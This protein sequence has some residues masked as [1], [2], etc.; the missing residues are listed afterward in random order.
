M[1]PASILP[2]SS[3]P[4]QNPPTTQPRAVRQQA[5]SVGR[6]FL[7][8]IFV[9]FLV[10]LFPQL[11]GYG[12]LQS[13]PTSH[14]TESPKPNFSQDTTS[15]QHRAGRALQATQPTSLPFGGQPLGPTPSVFNRSGAVVHTNSTRTDVVYVDLATGQLNRILV[16]PDGTPSTPLTFTAS[17]SGFSTSNSVQTPH[18]LI[19]HPDG[20]QWVVYMNG[21]TSVNAN[22]Y[23]AHILTDNTVQTYPVDTDTNFPSKGFPKAALLSNGNLIVFWQAYLTD[24]SG[25]GMLAQELDTTTGQILGSP[26]SVNLTTTNNQAIFEIVELGTDT[27]G[28]IFLDTSTSP[29]R[30]LFRKFDLS[31]TFSGPEVVLATDSP[32]L[33][34]AY[35]TSVVDAANRVLSVFQASGVDDGSSVH[36][37]PHNS[38]GTPDVHGGF[39][40]NRYGKGNQYFPVIG[41]AKDRPVIA[42]SSPEFGI[43]QSVI[44][45]N[46]EGVDLQ[47]LDPRLKPTG[48]Q[49]HLSSP[50]GY[51]QSPSI[52]CNAGVCELAFSTTEL[53]G[54]NQGSSTNR[55]QLPLVPT[56]PLPP[57][58]A[59]TG[60]PFSQTLTGDCF[61]DPLHQITLSVTNTPAWMSVTQNPYG[62]IGSFNNG[63]PSSKFVL[64]S[65]IGFLAQPD[66]VVIVDLKNL[67]APIELGTLT[68]FSG[69][70]SVCIIG[71][72]LLI[73]DDTSLYVYPLDRNFEAPTLGTTLVGST[74]FGTGL[75]DDRAAYTQY[76]YFTSG[77]KV[78]VVDT[79]ASPPTVQ[80]TTT[81]GGTVAQV[82]VYGN[83]LIAAVGTK[84]LEVRDRSNPLGSL[85]AVCTNT[86]PNNHN[87]IAI[88]NTTGIG[89]V[90]D[91]NGGVIA[92]DLTGIQTGIP[93]PVLF[94]VPVAGNCLCLELFDGRLYVGTTTGYAI[95]AISPTGAT[96]LESGTV[97]GGIQQLENRGGVLVGSNTDGLVILAKSVTLSGTPGTADI[98]TVTPRFQATTQDQAVYIPLSIQVSS[99]ASVPAELTV[100]SD[101][102]GT[103]KTPAIAV[104]A[105][106]SQ[107]VTWQGP[108]GSGQGVFFQV[109]S[110]DRIKLGLQKR[111]AIDGLADDKPP[112]LAIAPTTQDALIAWP[113]T[114]ATPANRG[115]SFFVVNQNQAL[116]GQSTLINVDVASATSPAVAAQNNQ[117]NVFWITTSGEV[118][119]QAV[120]FQNTPTGSITS[121]LSTDVDITGGLSATGF[122]DGKGWALASVDTTADPQTTVVRLT[123]QTPSASFSVQLPSISGTQ[124]RN[125]VVAQ[126]SNGDL[127]VACEHKTGTNPSEVYVTVYSATGTLKYGPILASQ[128]GV[129]STNPVI[130][131][132]L[133]GRFV[134]SWYGNSG[135]ADEIDV[136]FFSNNPTAWA[137]RQ[138]AIANV[139][140]TGTH[141]SPALGQISN[142]KVVVA[143]QTDKDGTPDIVAATLSLKI[144]PKTPVPT[145]SV[146]I[147]TT[148]NITLDPDSLFQ[149]FNSPVTIQSVSGPSFVSYNSNTKVVTIT[150]PLRGQGTYTVTITGLDGDGYTA[151]STFTVIVPNQTPVLPP[152]TAG[153][154]QLGI[155]H[156][157]PTISPSDADGDPLTTT[158]TA[159]P[160]G[161]PRPFPTTPSLGNFTV[162]SNALNVTVSDPSGATTWRQWDL[163]VGSSLS[164][165]T[166]PSVTTNENQDQT[167]SVLFATPAT[168]VTVTVVD[169]PLGTLA[170]PGQAAATSF[171]DAPL[172]LNTLEFKPYDNAF[173]TSTIRLR[174]ND[175][176]NPEQEILIPVTVQQQTRPLQQ[177]KPVAP[178]TTYAGLSS[179]LTWDAD[180]VVDPRNTTITY[181]VVQADGSPLPSWLVFDGV[182]TLTATT[183]TFQRGTTVS[184][185]LIANDAHNYE[186]AKEIPFTWTIPANRAPVLTTPYLPRTLAISNS[187]T[188]ADLAPDT[189]LTDTDGDPLSFSYFDETTG[190]PITFPW[191]PSQTALGLHRI[192]ITATDVLGAQTDAFQE[193]TVVKSNT[194]TLPTALSTP[195]DQPIILTPIIQSPSTSASL[196]ATSTI[197]GIFTQLDGTPITFPLTGTPSQLSQS[198][199]FVPDLNWFGTGEVVF[200]ISD[201]NLNPVEV[202]RV[203]TTVQQ[204]SKPIQTTTPPSQSTY[205][206]L[207]VGF[208]LPSTTFTDQRGDAIVYSA[209]LIDGSP[210]PAHLI[211]FDP[212][213]RTFT[214]VTTLGAIGTAPLTIKV[215]GTLKNNPTLETPADITFVWSIKAPLSTTLSE[216]PTPLNYV[217]GNPQKLPSVPLTSQGS[218]TVRLVYTL[219]GYN[220]TATLAC[221]AVAPG[222]TITQDQAAGQL[223]LTASEAD[224]ANLMYVADNVYFEPNLGINGPG[225][226]KIQASNSQ[227]SLQR[228]LPVQGTALP[229]APRLSASL[230][231]LN[232]KSGDT[233]SINLTDYITCDDGPVRFTTVQIL[234]LDSGLSFSNGILSGTVQAG[235]PDQPSIIQIVVDT[236]NAAPTPGEIR[237][238]R[239]L[240]T[241]TVQPSTT[242]DI[243]RSTQR[244][245]SG[246]PCLLPLPNVTL[247]GP[248]PAQLLLDFDAS[249]FSVTPSENSSGVVV[250][251]STHQY[252]FSGLA[253]ALN[254]FWAGSRWS[255][256]TLATTAS[257]LNITVGSTNQPPKT[258][259]IPISPYFPQVTVPFNQTRTNRDEFTLFLGSR[260]RGLQGTL[261]VE[262]FKDGRP[263]SDFSYNADT[264]ELTMNP[265]T[266]SPSGEYTFRIRG[267]YCGEI[268]HAATITFPDLDEETAAILDSITDASSSI[269][270]GTAAAALGVALMFLQC[271]FPDTIKKLR[272]R[273]IGAICRRI[274]ERGLFQKANTELSTA[275]LKIDKACKT[276]LKNPDLETE[277]PGSIT[278]ITLQTQFARDLKQIEDTVNQTLSP[279]IKLLDKNPTQEIARRLEHLLTQF[280]N[281]LEALGLFTSQKLAAPNPQT[282]LT[283]GFSTQ[284]AHLQKILTQLESVCN[285]GK[286]AAHLLTKKSVAK[287]GQLS[288]P[289]S[290]ETSRRSSDTSSTVPSVGS[291][292]DSL[293]SAKPPGA[294]TPSTADSHEPLTMFRSLPLHD[295]ETQTDPLSPLHAAFEAIRRSRKAIPTHVPMPTII[296]I[297]TDTTLNQQQAFKLGT[298]QLLATRLGR[299]PLRI[300]PPLTSESSDTPPAL[301]PEFTPDLPN[302]AKTE[303][304][305]QSQ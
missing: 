115:I 198:I 252:T 261:T 287:L 222:V 14:P 240:T 95:Y 278:L 31:G 149:E 185:K 96:L 233:V 13:T 141:A 155:Q 93:V 34:L 108:L 127:A 264:N 69:T 114:S 8:L 194:Y 295:Q 297:P 215:T 98:G 168:Q 23:A 43:T 229:S 263:V 17:S 241:W 273:M 4:P 199:R 68:G 167:L 32:S 61:Y 55:V 176:I 74:P 190:L 298:A 91:R 165:T 138:T 106:G 81:L 209:T 288:D 133:T 123:K 128:A 182:R 271:V 99:V 212:D 80:A 253:Q 195:E 10:R 181:T 179:T 267:D 244:F 243:D 237:T 282:A 97:N 188:E 152:I 163:T 62:Q 177:Q 46:A 300:L 40:I 131:V 208:Q 56:Q 160:S 178:Q 239:F 72:K 15:I 77:N 6:V 102:T 48:P 92:Y 231:V 285:H 150:P 249:R 126:L 130:R 9:L 286:S 12:Q 245:S 302:V 70:P 296:P 64:Y 289:P 26:Q 236:D 225:Q 66:R 47:F 260:I 124:Q 184:L 153:T 166:P 246:Q 272:D 230:P 132:D 36:L 196:S 57:V 42:W 143:Y 29:S 16:S 59:P 290:P 94:R 174:I 248:F 89:W 105:D 139:T 5:A 180:T 25:Y 256:T 82:G 120:S 200:T 161:A 119:T 146:F 116:F 234:P 148:L 38:T 117:F 71:H 121:L 266:L 280:Q 251:H 53:G 283:E 255:P 304:G 18:K 164:C 162:G 73:G 11:V 1:A 301:A 103:Q 142:E 39:R 202:T 52:D 207:N 303:S 171:T 41:Q 206:G 192:H 110:P 22:I 49:V 101:P 107:L 284:L 147:G 134:V 37:L 169:S 204:T 187:I 172:A 216:T 113:V 232:L 305:S 140:R 44:A 210:L 211:Q 21:T 86:T 60:T 270:G 54:I 262:V 112:A 269:A 238:A 100:H 65:D 159:I 78:H 247:S 299:G 281:H 3:T 104:Y 250:G 85:S 226:I 218:G 223:T 83:W 259:S 58:A 158:I 205:A 19:V 277:A 170:R 201:N 221:L 33:A 197:P 227:M 276:I 151:T 137:S 189:H 63:Q 224:I 88:D 136:R 228:T 268:F 125:P 275:L 24:G 50:T 90:S 265:G 75:Q 214:P 76:G 129:D 45:N 118:Q 219:E 183:Q 156:P 257:S 135:S 144:A 173:G 203:P 154:G 191:T 293:G 157:G 122:R 292:L 217:E 242:A 145:Q 27:F 79:I 28:V 235:R 111:V 274:K 294:S 20:S 193:V 220:N 84:G 186:A 279:I 51:A 67:K 291:S 7:S 87:A 254:T 35:P 175:G 109:L 258:V 2:I 30:T 213:T